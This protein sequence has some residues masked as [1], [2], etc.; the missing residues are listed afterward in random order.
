MNQQLH[1]RSRKALGGELPAPSQSPGVSTALPSN[2]GNSGPRSRS[3]STGTNSGEQR[4]TLPESRHYAINEPGQKEDSLPDWYVEGPGRRVGYDDLT[5]I[6]W[7]YE[8]T[9]ERQRLRK[10]LALNPGL[11]GSLRQLFDASHVWLVLVASGISVGCVAA[12][13]NIASDW[14]GD[15]KTGYCKNGRGG[16]HFYLNKQ[17]CCWGHDEFAQ[18]QDW[19]PWPSAFGISSSGAQYVIGYIFFIMFSVRTQSIPAV[20]R[21][22]TSRADT[23]RRFC[24]C[25]CPTLLPICPSQWNSRDQD[26]AGRLRD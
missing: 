19:T 17:F 5:A 24:G 14:L 8:Y 26:S 15:I 10:L 7:I 16:G 23:F 1:S 9:K 6:D 2:N 12:L 3:R 22:I 21:L 4:D 13:I 11:V 25:S 20:R 18:C